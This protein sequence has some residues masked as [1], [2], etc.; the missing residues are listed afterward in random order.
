MRLRSPGVAEFRIYLC[1]QRLS[2]NNCRSATTTTTNAIVN[3]HDCESMTERG[4]KFISQSRLGTDTI[5][6]QMNDSDLMR[7]S[8]VTDTKRGG[9]AE[10]VLTNAIS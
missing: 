8:R 7:L 10:G 3:S 9:G 6:S 2:A 5:S 4:I 1:A